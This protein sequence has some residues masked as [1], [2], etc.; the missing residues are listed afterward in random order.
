MVSQS[1]RFALH[2]AAIGLLALILSAVGH[3]ILI[4][5]TDPSS[6]VGRTVIALVDDA[7]VTDPPPGFAEAMG[8]S[9]DGTVKPDGSC[10]TPAAYPG[11]T[12]ACRTHDFGYDLL[13]Y[14][15]ETGEPLG[16]WA[17]LGIDRRFHH[18]MVTACDTLGCHVLAHLYGLAVA[19]NSVR[20]GFTVPTEEPV[21]PWAMAG[22]FTVAAAT[23]LSS[24]DPNRTRPRRRVELPD[25]IASHA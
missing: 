1:L 21:A 14:A 5:G 2:L 11:F 19:L 3:L 22:V 16:P 17:R 20:Q 10:S 25:P 4:P 24:Y 18:D 8:Y 9:P 13:R 15:S 7:P 12:E 23:V 6:L